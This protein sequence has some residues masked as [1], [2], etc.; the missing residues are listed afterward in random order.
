MGNP[1][2]GQEEAAS[3][4]VIPNQG[5]WALYTMKLLLLRSPAASSKCLPPTTPSH[6]D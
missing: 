5:T 6:L 2:A 1:P 3:P 4:E